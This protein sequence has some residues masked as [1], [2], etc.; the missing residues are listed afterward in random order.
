M[1]DIVWAIDPDQDRLEDLAHRMRRFASDLLTSSGVRLQFRV[2]A[3]GQGPEVGA[4]IRRQIFLI[5]KEALNNA[6]RHSACTEVQID[7]SLAR[8][9]LSLTLKD[10]GKGFEWGCVDQGHGLSSMRQRAAELG[11]S[12]EVDSVPDHG[13]TIRLQVP[14]ARPFIPRWKKALHKQVVRIPRLRRTMK[15]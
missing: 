5:F 7:F 3:G 6:V 12:F 9:V 15:L 14:L 10:N 8:G 4:G 11:G 13:T 2:P 1:S